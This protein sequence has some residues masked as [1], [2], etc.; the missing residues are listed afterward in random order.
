MRTE[1]EGYICKLHWD[2]LGNSNVDG[3]M[4]LCKRVLF[5]KFHRYCVIQEN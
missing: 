3:I 5:L 2:I 1:K 4:I